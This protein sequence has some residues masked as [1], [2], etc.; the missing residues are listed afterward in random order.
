MVSTKLVTGMGV[1]SMSDGK[2]KGGAGSGM[3]TKDETS[4]ANHIQPTTATTDKT[5]NTTNVRRILSGYG[6]SM[7]SG[8]YSC[9][10]RQRR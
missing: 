4:G 9:A 6:S 3:I 8:R 2:V 5:A 1:I 10:Y 7:S